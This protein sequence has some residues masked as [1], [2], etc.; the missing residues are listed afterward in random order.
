MELSMLCKS[1]LS[2]KTI[3]ITYIILQ[4]PEKIYSVEKKEAVQISNVIHIY[5][6]LLF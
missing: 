1:V 3:V 5:G 4:G 6:T 2:N